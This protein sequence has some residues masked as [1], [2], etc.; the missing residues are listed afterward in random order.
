MLSLI[1][2]RRIYRS[3]C[4]CFCVET[5]GTHMKI[6]KSNGDKV[7]ELNRG[8][9]FVILRKQRDKLETSP[10]I[11]LPYSHIVEQTWPYKK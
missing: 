5:K 8:A 11:I 6:D 1:I 2:F 9:H 10:L 3:W 7:G 4:F